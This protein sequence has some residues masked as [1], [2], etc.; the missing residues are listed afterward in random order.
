ML[1]LMKPAQPTYYKTPALAGDTANKCLKHRTSAGVCRLDKQPHRL[2]NIGL[3]GDTDVGLD[4]A[5]P[6]YTRPIAKPFAM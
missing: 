1:G 6:T 2:P 4:E 5:S 3:N